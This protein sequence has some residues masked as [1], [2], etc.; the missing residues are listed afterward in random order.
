MNRVINM[1]VDLCTGRYHPGISLL[2]CSWTNLH[3]CER[4]VEKCVLCGVC[5]CV[6]ACTYVC[7]CVCVCI[8]GCL[9]MCAQCL[10]ACFHIFNAVSL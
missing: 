9:H 6:L 10:Y 7:V 1:S 5:A 2:Y 3:L 8:H 4:L